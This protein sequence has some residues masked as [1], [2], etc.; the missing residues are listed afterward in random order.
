MSS[1]RRA[2]VL[3]P[4]RYRRSY[5]GN[6]CSSI[7]G[8]SGSPG[9]LFARGDHI[10]HLGPAGSTL[11]RQ[12]RQRRSQPVV[13]SRRLDPVPLHRHLAGCCVGG[14]T[15]RRDVGSGGGRSASGLLESEA[16]MGGADAAGCQSCAQPLQTPLFR[17]HSP[18]RCARAGRPDC[19]CWAAEPRPSEL[20]GKRRWHAPERRAASSLSPAVKQA[21]AHVSVS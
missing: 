5:L 12:P 1:P 10:S 20:P 18:L 11:A 3:R 13:L 7:W 6:S 15:R 19:P 2:F 9:Q 17:L 21:T 14:Q 16:K 8:V 4:G